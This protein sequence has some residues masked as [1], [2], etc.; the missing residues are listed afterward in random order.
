MTHSVETLH[1]EHSSVLLPMEALPPSRSPVK[2]NTTCCI[3]QKFTPSESNVSYLVWMLQCHGGGFSLR[4]RRIFDKQRSFR[5]TSNLWSS[6]G[7]R[8]NVDGMGRTYVQILLF[9]EPSTYLKPSTHSQTF[10]TSTQIQ[11]RH[12]F[13]SL[14]TCDIP[15]KG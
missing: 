1:F 5:A 10:M 9:S 12:S 11:L 2:P 3:P 14:P 4:C 8:I 13:I 15:G 6:L 7:G